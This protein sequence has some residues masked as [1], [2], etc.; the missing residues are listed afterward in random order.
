MGEGGQR[1]IAREAGRCKP[2]FRIFSVVKTF[3]NPTATELLFVRLRQL[4]PES[5]RRWGRMS[6]A[7]MLCHLSD[8]MRHS[9][10]E[11][12]SSS[13]RPTW[14]RTKGMKWI[15]LW[16][17]IPWPHGLRSRPELDP[18]RGGTQPG[19]FAKDLATLEELTRR[20]I[21]GAATLPGAHPLF[22]PLT[23]KEWLRWCWLH[24]DHHLRQFGV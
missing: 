10:G 23:A 14:W 21:A 19:D 24:H 7:Q 16:V 17:P 2:A 5:R 15:G 1:I 8:A 12:L 9:L 4:S 18:Q 3:A 13:Y 20:F 6:P 22:G 11:R